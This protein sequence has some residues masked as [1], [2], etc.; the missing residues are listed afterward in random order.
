MKAPIVLDNQ[1]EN[2]KWLTRSTPLKNK[3]NPN[4]V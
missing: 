2:N 1:G 3:P 4:S